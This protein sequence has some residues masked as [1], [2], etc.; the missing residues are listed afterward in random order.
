MVWA[1]VFPDF[2]PTER[3]NVAIYIMGIM[4][5]KFALENLSGCFSNIILQRVPQNP[6]T[7]WSTIVS[8]NFAA[9]SIGSLLVSP[10]M[11]RWPTS[12]VLSTAIITFGLLVAIVPILEFFTGGGRDGT[13][14]AG[15]KKYK[16]GQYD[17]MIV[18][19]LF[20][21]IGIFHGII[22]LVRRVIPKDIVGADALKLKRMDG[23]V[24][25]FYQIAG[26][27]GAL[28]SRVWIDKINYAYTLAIIP[29]VYLFVVAPIWSRIRNEEEKVAAIN[30]KS[31]GAIREIGAIFRAF[32][33]SVWIGAKLTLTNRSLVWLT[34]AYSVPFVIHRYKENVLYA[35]YANFGLSRGAYQQQLIAGSN[36]GELLGALLIVIY[37]ITVP[38]PIPWQ[39]LDALS[40]LTL[41]IYPLAAPWRENIEGWVWF[42]T[43]YNIPVSLGWSAGD[44]SLVAYIQS[45]LGS[46]EN[47]DSSISPLG[48]VMSFLYVFYIAVFATLSQA[49]GRLQDSYVRDLRSKFG[50]PREWK[51][52]IGLA[53]TQE[54]MMW[55]AGFVVSLACFLIL[56]STFVPKGSFAW[57]P[58]VIDSDEDLVEIKRQVAAHAARMTTRITRARR[59]P[60]TTPFLCKERC[61]M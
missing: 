39:R 55:S 24:M 22:E 33:R 56:V 20:P 53:P 54:A 11:K 34:F 8:V 44:C 28:L 1:K 40:L 43:L 51:N 4:G 60:S 37:A 23:M 29:V 35:H 47:V 12:R 59:M 7:V 52:L 2:T 26:T 36:F 6:S 15:E 58:A 48:A 38:T 49:I 21:V 5:Y 61:C 3:R 50:A 16:F 14:T 42:L 45:R 41:W 17:P 30:Y 27:S 13:L 25:V 31:Q 10:L 32:F 57:N 46:I 19:Y 9:Q 18:G